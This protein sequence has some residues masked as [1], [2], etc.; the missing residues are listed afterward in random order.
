MV[1]V[2]CAPDARGATVSVNPSQDNSI[3]AENNNSNAAGSI[4]VGRTNG[5]LGTTIRRG[6]IQFDIASNI[7][8]G[9]TINSVSLT[10]QTLIDGPAAANQI[11]ELHALSAAWGEGTSSGVGTGA[12]PTTGDATWNFRLFNSSVWTNSGGDFGATSGTTTLGGGSQSVFS[13]QPGMVADVQNWL[14]NPASNFGWILKYSDETTLGTA[15]A[16]GSRES[17]ASQRPTLTID[18]APVPEP[19]S[20]IMF[21]VGAFLLTSRRRR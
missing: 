11:L 1:A 12:A 6:L 10:L 19:G 15:R 8:A 13:S 14:N 20:L 7:P 18:Y 5:S 3:Y 16:F 2:L 21:A 9:A 4:F 17:Q